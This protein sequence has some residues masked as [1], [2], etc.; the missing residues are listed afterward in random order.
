MKKKSIKIEQLSLDKETI[1]RLNEKQLGAVAGG[2]TVPQ[3]LSCNAEMEAEL[4]LEFP[5]SCCRDSCKGPN[6]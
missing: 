1:S 3:S 5:E 4:A 2:Q 6:L